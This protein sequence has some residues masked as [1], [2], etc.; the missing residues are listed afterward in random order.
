MDL[1]QS[2]FGIETVDE[3]IARS[4]LAS[5]GAYTAVGTYDHQE[6]VSLVVNLSKVSGTAVPDLMAI[7]GK[8]LFS[9]FAVLYPDMVGSTE[10]GLDFLESVEDYIHVEVKKLYPKA[11]LPRFD[12]SRPS[13]DELIMI[14]HSNKHFEDLAGGL[15]A[16]CLEHFQED[17]SIERA[18]PR[19]EGEGVV[20]RIRRHH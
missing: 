11:D 18:E 1:V 19:D 20:F 2:A 14:Y 3:I 6:I 4:D 5:G 16:G 10:D 15:I 12:C 17:A 7:F 13:P 8:H 9:R